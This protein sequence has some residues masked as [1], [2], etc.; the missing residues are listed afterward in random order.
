MVKKSIVLQNGLQDGYE[1]LT[2]KNRGGGGAGRAYYFNFLLMLTFLGLQNKYD[3]VQMHAKWRNNDLN[4]SLPWANFLALPLKENFLHGPSL[5]CCNKIVP[6][7]KLKQGCEITTINI[8]RSTLSKRLTRFASMT[9]IKD[10]NHTKQ[11]I[12]LNLATNEKA[13]L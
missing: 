1:T 4:A 11:R 9:S 13:N 10:P 6:C 3:C 5:S 7:Y 12:K 2:D 8:E